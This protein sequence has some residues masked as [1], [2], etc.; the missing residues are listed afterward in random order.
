MQSI[1]NTKRTYFSKAQKC[2]ILEELESS[3]ITYTDLAR[4]HGIHPVTIHKWRR[5][6]N[7]SQQNKLDTLDIDELLSEK[8]EQ[9]KEIEILKRAIANLTVK[10]EILQSA[11]DILKK[12]QKKAT[13][14]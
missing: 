9:D 11:N 6:M 2:A 12:S 10:N 4:K 13:R 14:K 3:G 8:K 5:Q 1:E 7:S